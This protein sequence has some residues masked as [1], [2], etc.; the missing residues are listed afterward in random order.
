MSYKPPL[1]LDL[2][3]ATVHGYKNEVAFDQKGVIQ[4]PGAPTTPTWN[5]PIKV[6]FG[7]W[8]PAESNNHYCGAIGFDVL[9]GDPT[10]PRDDNPRRLEKGFIALK[11]DPDPVIEFYLQRRADTTEDKD[12]LC[13]LA[14]SAKGLELDPKHAGGI[15]LKGFGPVADIARPSDPFHMVSPDGNTQLELQNDGNFVRYRKDVDGRF[16]ADWDANSA[17]QRLADLE[18]LVAQLSSGHHA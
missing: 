14:I 10:Y 7:G 13:V 9:E 2:P 3:D 16:I 6:R 11:M 8:K 18:I 12:M 1:L 17:N 4:E 15:G 5:D